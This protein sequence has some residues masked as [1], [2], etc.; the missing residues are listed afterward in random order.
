[1]GVTVRRPPSGIVSVLFVVL[2]GCVGGEGVPSSLPEAEV[3]ESQAEIRIANSLSTD[4]L[5]LNAIGTNPVANGLLATSRLTALFSAAGGDPRILKQLHDPDAQKFMEYLVSCA[6]GPNQVLWYYNPRGPTPGPRVWGGKAGLCTSWLNSAPSEACLNR[7]SGCLLSRNNALGRRVELSI[8]GEVPGDASIFYLEP[9]TK[10]AEYEPSTASKLV[11]FGP[12]SEQTTG[13][14]RDCGWTA[15]GIGTCVPGTPVS[16]GAGGAASCPGPSVG[17]SSGAQMVLRVCSGVVGCDSSGSTN[18]GEGDGSCSGSDPIVSFTCP[19]GGYYS[20]MTAAWDSDEVGVATV[21]VLDTLRSRYALSE[22]Q[23]FAVREGAFYGNI[24]EP[25]ALATKVYVEE[26][27]GGNGEPSRF[28]VKGDDAVIKGAI[29]RKMYSC[30]DPSWGNGSAYSTYRVCAL[31]GSGA[32]CAAT[33]AGPCWDT[34][35]EAGKC[36]VDDGPMVRGDGDYEECEDI[37]GLLWT[38]P[39]TTFLHDPCGPVSSRTRAKKDG[40]AAQSP[41]GLCTRTIRPGKER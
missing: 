24:F 19:A 16:V 18:L 10:P 6:L 11:S 28:V 30:Y 36:A 4:A 22:K 5:V 12:C 39:V 23:V 1:M 32:N 26:I 41:D 27:R 35:N 13:A 9:V 17:S 3:G 21:A 33:V 31:P 7:V 14:Q 34:A 25:E 8:R 20:V 15:D 40:M 38:E 2:A 29:Y 37:H